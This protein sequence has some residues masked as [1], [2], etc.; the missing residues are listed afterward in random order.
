MEIIVLARLEPV[1]FAEIIPVDGNGA[2]RLQIEAYASDFCHDAAHGH[3]REAEHIL[4]SRVREITFAY[5]VSAGEHSIDAVQLDGGAVARVGRMVGYATPYDGLSDEAAP[6]ILVGDFLFARAS[7]L[8]STLG[9]QAV[10]IIAETFAELVTGQM[11][12]GH[13][14][15]SRTV[16][17]W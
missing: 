3:L 5:H 16:V 14:K 17:I 10:R 4:G 8:V 6:A 2:S 7:R 9:P 1:L 13:S 11:R 15:A 12:D